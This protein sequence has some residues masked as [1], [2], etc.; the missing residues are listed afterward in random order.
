MEGLKRAEELQP[1]LLVCEIFSLFKKHSYFNA[2][3]NNGKKY[4]IILEIYK[5]SNKPI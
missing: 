5:N 3:M 1:L 2:I 4:A